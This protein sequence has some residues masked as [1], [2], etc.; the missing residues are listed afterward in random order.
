MSAADKVRE[1]LDQSLRVALSDG[2][3]IIGTF[4]CFDKQRNILLSGARELRGS[5]DGEAAAPSEHHIGL[6]L[7]PW[8]WVTACHAQE[9]A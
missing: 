5:D 9:A 7:V 3:V 4:L 1:L 6:V 8:K 2:R